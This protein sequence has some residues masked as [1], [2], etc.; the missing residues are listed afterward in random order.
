MPLLRRL[1][2]AR[3]GFEVCV[4]ILAVVCGVLLT[5]VLIA[6]GGAG[7]QALIPLVFAVYGVIHIAVFTDFRDRGR[8]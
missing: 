2:S 7:A 8:R 6:D 4:G 1:A 5:V 3:P